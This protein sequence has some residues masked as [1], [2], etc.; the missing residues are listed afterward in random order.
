[1]ASK[2]TFFLLVAA[3][4]LPMISTAK[5]FTVGDGKGWTADF[6]YQAWANGKRSKPEINLVIFKYPKG[7]HT[8]QKVDE[9]GFAKC[10]KLNEGVLSTGNDVI[11][12][13]T[14]GRKWY[15]SGVG[16]HCKGGQKLV[17]TVVS[18]SSPKNGSKL[19]KSFANGLIVSWI[20]VLIS[21]TITM[22]TVLMV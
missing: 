14:S 10:T 2:H 22:V 20:P 15:T 18:K 13:S 7:A 9:D 8:V 4:A 5:E 12:L 3:I 19:G 16:Q 6:D 21:A 11:T 1:M 17:I